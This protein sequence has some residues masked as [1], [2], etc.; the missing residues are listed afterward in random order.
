M[1]N[2]NK[3]SYLLF[4]AFLQSDPV[5]SIGADVHFVGFDK[6]NFVRL[7]GNGALCTYG[8]DEPQEPKVHL[9]RVKKEGHVRHC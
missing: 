1:I 9:W 3:V 8:R 2:S 5:L 6:V 7:L 4:G